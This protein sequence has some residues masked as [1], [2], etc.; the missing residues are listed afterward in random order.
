MTVRTWHLETA[1]VAAVLATVAL[2][3]GGALE[4]IGAGAVLLSFGH[5]SV[6]ERMREREAARTTPSVE[7]HRWSTRYFVG[8]EALWL[9]YFV[10]HGSW[11]AL[12]GVGLFLLYPVWRRFWR[13]RKPLVA[14]A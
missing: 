2:V 11:S 7:C 10:L 9:V 5:A 8:K 6:G 1:V 14:A 12:A 4:L 13:S 3:S